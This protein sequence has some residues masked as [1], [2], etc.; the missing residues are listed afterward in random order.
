MPSQDRKTLVQGPPGLGSA[1]ACLVPEHLGTGLASY[2]LCPSS[3][4]PKAAGSKPQ[5]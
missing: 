5:G 1:D 3:R 2:Y 4:C